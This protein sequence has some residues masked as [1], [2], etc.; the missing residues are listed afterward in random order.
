MKN[1][2]QLKMEKDYWFLNH[3]NTYGSRRRSIAKIFDFE[4]EDDLLSNPQVIW[5]SNTA[6]PRMKFSIPVGN[7]NKK[8][9]LD[10]IKELLKKYK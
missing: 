5:G 7:I 9:A 10:S 1:L 2:K 8:S 4:Y 3:T 6:Q